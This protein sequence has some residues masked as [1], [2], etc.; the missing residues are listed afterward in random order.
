VAWHCQLEVRTNVTSLCD[1]LTDKLNQVIEQLFN[2][3]EI[4]VRVPATRIL[5][6]EIAVRVAELLRAF[7]DASRV[8]IVFALLNGEVNVGALAEAV[9][10]SDSAVSHHLRGL[11]QLRLV[12]ARKD[13]QQV[14][15]SVDDDHIVEIFRQ[16]VNH[17]QHP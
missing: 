9:G 3:L 1:P 14:F 16:V 4:A 13:G 8:R 15:Y 2:Y 10:L 17:A 12:R 7:G 11:R 5:D 6:P